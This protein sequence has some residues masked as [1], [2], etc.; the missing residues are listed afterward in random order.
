MPPNPIIP[1]NPELKQKARE[2]RKNPTFAEKILW[3]ALRRKQLDFEFHRQVPINDFI[4]DF[5]CYELKLVIEV[6]G[7]SHN[8]PD[9]KNYDAKRQ[10]KLESLGA[11][12]LRFEDD[13]VLGN[14]EK[15]VGK[16]KEWIEQNKD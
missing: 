3:M 14:V 6:D 9:V 4:V 13:K 1:Y 12:F 10:L 16:I 7:V 5:Y 15:V 11:R 2:L 8:D